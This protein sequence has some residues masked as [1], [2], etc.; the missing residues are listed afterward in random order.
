MVLVRKVNSVMKAHSYS[1]KVCP[2]NPGESFTYRCQLICTMHVPIEYS[3]RV[4]TFRN[5]I[6]FQG[7]TNYDTT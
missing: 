3:I 1:F 6:V 5:I 2:T 7:R 4:R